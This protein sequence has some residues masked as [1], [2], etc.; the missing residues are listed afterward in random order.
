MRCC[1]GV[2]S[3]DLLNPNIIARDLGLADTT[4]LAGHGGGAIPVEVTM[5]PKE[6]ARRFAFIMASAAEQ[7][8]QQDQ[9]VEK[10]AS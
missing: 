4:K 2:R 10:E 3:S 8:K 6:L 7:A 9:D 5:T 1:H